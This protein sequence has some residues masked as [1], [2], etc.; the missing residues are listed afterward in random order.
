M[1]LALRGTPWDAKGRLQEADLG[2]GCSACVGLSYQH[3]KRCLRFRQNVNKDPEFAAR[4]GLTQEQVQ[5]SRD[6]GLLQPVGQTN[7]AVVQGATPQTV[8]SASALSGTAAVSGTAGVTTASLRQLVELM[9]VERQEDQL[10]FQLERVQLWGSEKI[11]L[12]GEVTHVEVAVPMEKNQL[13]YSHIN[14]SDYYDLVNEDNRQPLDAQKVAE[15]VN[16]EMKF[17]EEQ[18]LGEP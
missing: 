4:V 17:L 12:V 16:R 3:S 14:P 9:A 13:D 5:L 7:I 15:G 10:R 1:M 2:R 6:R 11:S 8:A 18:R